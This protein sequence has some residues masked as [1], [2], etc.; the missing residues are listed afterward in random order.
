M[1]WDTGEVY[2]SVDNYPIAPAPFMEIIT[3]SPT[4]LF[5]YLFWK[6]IGHICMGLFVDFLFCFIGLLV[7]FYTNNI[8]YYPGY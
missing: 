2:I 7:Y 6:L 4:V 1:M 3:L 8:L 5:W